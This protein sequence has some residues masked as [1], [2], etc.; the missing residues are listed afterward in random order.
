MNDMAEDNQ[1]EQ[2]VLSVIQDWNEA[3]MFGTKEVDA[4]SKIGQKAKAAINAYTTN[5][6]IEELDAIDAAYLKSD[7][8][9]VFDTINDRIA[10]LRK[11]L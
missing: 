8:D 3:M 9:S 5:K 2:I 6:I 4:I 7:Y 10:E 1:L 11:T